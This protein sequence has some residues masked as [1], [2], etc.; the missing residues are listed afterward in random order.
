MFQQ[1]NMPRPRIL[2]A[3]DAQVFNL[4]YAYAPLP[5][6]TSVYRD[7]QEIGQE[8]IEW[9]VEARK[10]SAQYPSDWRW[11]VRAK[12]VYEHLQDLRH[13]EHQRKAEED[14]RLS[15][16]ASYQSQE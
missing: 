1:I 2:A 9:V 12:T 4:L 13:K 14:I 8:A 16:L 15:M 5:F 11:A 3:A 6:V 7:L 10:R